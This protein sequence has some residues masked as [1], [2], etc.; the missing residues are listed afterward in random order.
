MSELIRISD[1]VRHFRV[2]RGTLRALDG[3]SIAVT[4]GETLG[5]VGES[6]CGKSTLARLI[7]G[8]DRPTSGSVAIGGVDLGTASRAERRR[9]AR[10]CQM[11]FQDPFSSLNPRLKV[12]SI[13]AEP[14]V[15]H[16]VGDRA[17]R[18]A[19]VARL[20]DRVGLPRDAVRRYPHEFS[21]GQRQR[22][23]IARALATS[24]RILVADEPV[25]ALDVSVQAQI[26]NLIADLR[27]ELGLTVLLVSHDLQVVE[28]MSD[29]VTVMYL[30]RVVES[31]SRAAI[32]GSARH[33]YTRALL[34][35]SPRLRL[36]GEGAGD[37]AVQA[38]AG[39][40][41]SAIEPPS[42]CAFHPRC[43]LAQ[44]ACSEVLPSLSAVSPGHDVACHDA[45]D[46]AA[47]ARSG[48]DSTA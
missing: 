34:A 21:G 4:E 9:I 25:S 28:W 39:E 43:P 23:G 38:L 30:G 44:A 10:I 2:P 5:I 26:L 20:L 31:G 19:E 45:H 14:L 27:D 16:R 35:A 24:P 40:A 8:I 1:L 32:F 22:I 42:G 37:D 6:G 3:V 17:R 36:P 41:P 46:W 12:G 48:A 7:V 29:R 18:A 11:V 13:I 15:I 47:T 33:P